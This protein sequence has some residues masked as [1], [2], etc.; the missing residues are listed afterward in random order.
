MIGEILFF[1]FLFLV[2]LLCYLISKDACTI[3][4]DPNEDF[5]KFYGMDLFLKEMEGEK[6]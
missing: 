5:R 1:S 6:E 4:I 3:R 2:F